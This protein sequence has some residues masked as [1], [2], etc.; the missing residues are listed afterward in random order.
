MFVKD[1]RKSFGPHNQGVPKDTIYGNFGGGTGKMTACWEKG[2]HEE[3]TDKPSSLSVASHYYT[4]LPVVH[5]HTLD[6]TTSGDLCRSRVLFTAATAALLS[7][8]QHRS[9]LLLT[10]LF[11]LL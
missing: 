7:C 1:R 9:S 5:D 11:T 8:H 10:I 4:L 3:S 6:V 2:H